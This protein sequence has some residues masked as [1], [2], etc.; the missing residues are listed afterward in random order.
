MEKY[1]GKI[2]KASFGIGGYNDAQI[3]ISFTLSGGGF[4]VGDFWGYW[5]IERSAYTKWSEEDRSTH[6][7]Q[8][9]MRIAKLLSD[10]KVDSVDRLKGVP[11][12][13]IFKD[14][15]LESWRIL[16]EVL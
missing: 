10:A 1:L 8:T 2:E 6:L 4:G 11:I 15:Q 12:E 3:G 9:V 16:K 5:S 14:N 7:G 13:L